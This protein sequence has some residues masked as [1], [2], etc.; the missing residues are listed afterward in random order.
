MFVNEHHKEL[1]Q[2]LECMQSGGL[3]QSAWLSVLIMHAQLI[4]A[5]TCTHMMLSLWYSC[6]YM[7]QSLVTPINFLT[8]LSVQNIKVCYGLYTETENG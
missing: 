5:C 2:G 8:C 7:Y 4:D 1:S 6:M 3:R